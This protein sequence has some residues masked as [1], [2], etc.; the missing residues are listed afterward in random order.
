MLEDQKTISEWAEKQFG[1][2]LSNARVA[3]RANEE[4]AKLL[5]AL[6]ANDSDPKALEEVA[7]VAIVLFRLADKLG[8]DLMDEVN[9]KMS[10]NRLR[11]WEQDST[12]RG[13]HIRDKSDL[14]PDRYCKTCTG[15]G[16]VYLSQVAD[17]MKG[18]CPECNGAD[19]K[20]KE[21]QPLPKKT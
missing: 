19:S 8:G 13:Y 5:R 1:P 16:W 18:P 21:V 10:R 3:A 12:G 7:D 14:V 20:T 6:T 11:K 15:L 2:V 9:R 17:Y 4:M